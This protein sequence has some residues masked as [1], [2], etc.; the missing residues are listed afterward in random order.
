MPVTWLKAKYTNYKPAKNTSGGHN[1]SGVKA[2]RRYARGVTQ[3]TE[4]ER[5]LVIGP[6]GRRHWTWQERQERTA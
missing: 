4:L 1:M 5:V 2:R 3:K 6:S